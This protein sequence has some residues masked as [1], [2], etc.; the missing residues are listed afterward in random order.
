MSPLLHHR[1]RTGARGAEV[2]LGFDT[3]AVPDCVDAGDEFPKWQRGRL[4]G[5]NVSHP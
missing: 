1:L 4:C 3:L 5:K 2:L